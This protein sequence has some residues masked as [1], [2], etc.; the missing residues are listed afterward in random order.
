[1]T[2]AELF[3][4]RFGPRIRWW[5]GVVIV[6][7]GLLNMG[8]FL[9]TG[10]EFLVI[11]CGFNADYLEITMTVMLVAAVGIYTIVGG[12]LSRAG[13]RLLAVPGDERRDCW[14]SRCS[15]CI[16]VPWNHVGRTVERDYGAGGFNP[17]VNPDLG[18]SYVIFQ[19]LLNAAAVLTWQTTIARLLSAKDTKTGQK[20]YTRTSF[21]FVCQFV[22]PGIWGIA[23]L[24]TLGPEIMATATVACHAAAFWPA[25]WPVGVT[26]LL[27]AAM[28]AADMSTDSSYML[29]WG[30]VIYNDLL[31]P[32]RKT[33]WSEQRGLRWNR[34]IVA[35]IGVFLMVYGLWYPLRRRNLDLSD[36]HRHDLPV[37][38]VD[39]ADR[40]LLLAAGQQLGRGGGHRRRRR[41][42]AG[43][44]GDRTD[45]RPRRSWPCRSVPNYPASRH[46]SARPWPWS[47]ARSSNP[48]VLQPRRRQPDDACRLLVVGGD[49]L[50]RLVLDDHGVRLGA[51]CVGY[52]Q[53]A[54]PP[55]LDQPGRRGR[56]RA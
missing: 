32:F 11:V 21:F 40:L 24:A 45:C 42:S 48:I 16:N 33:K 44:P 30:S 12:M 41:V 22:I 37:E 52:P 14:P 26:G 39:V 15:R 54:R 4:K 6:L 31:A 29:T 36:R 18:W 46:L 47:S 19:G 10:G 2:I 28:L 23:A 38:H 34:A 3:E 25:R 27:V 53:H 1:M 17:L 55:G 51:R 8:V 49:G 50:Y 13:D 5:S 43:L 7:G 56:S 20:V 9:R 35:L